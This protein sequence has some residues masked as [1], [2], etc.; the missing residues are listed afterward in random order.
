MSARDNVRPVVESELDRA[1]LV[2]ASRIEVSSVRGRVTLRGAVSTLPQGMEAQAIVSR[3]PGVKSV[4]NRV[5]VVLESRDRRSDSVLLATARMALDGD[6]SVPDGIHATVRKG[7]VVLTGAVP[8]ASQRERALR[9]IAGLPGVRDVRNN[10][11]VLPVPGGGD[12]A[13]RVAETLE[14]WTLVSDDSD[15]RVDTDHDIVRLFGRVASQAEHD[16]VLQAVW[17][18]PGVSQVTDE[19]VIGR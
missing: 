5:R 4:R 12:V 8:L 7:R 16:S 2:D 15:V 3:L 11:E 9:V 18:T 10:I 14:R 1:P 13:A 6:V 17:L 19:L